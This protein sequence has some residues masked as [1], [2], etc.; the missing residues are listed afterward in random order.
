VTNS[1][2]LIIPLIWAILST[3]VTI[4]CAQ[5]E[6]SGESIDDRSAA[7]GTK[8]ESSPLKTFYLKDKDGKLVPY[9]DIPFEKFEEIYKLYK[10]LD[11]P[12]RPPRHVLE[13][14]LI[15]GT[16]NR[17]QA[18]LQ[19]NL[20]VS[21]KV[22]GWVR[23]PLGLGNVVLRELAVVG[24][25]NQQFLEYEEEG[26][27]YVCWINGSK[28]KEYKIQL[29]TISR[30]GIVGNKTSLDLDAPQTPFSQ[31]KLKIPS[32]RLESEVSK[33]AELRGIAKS[34]NGQTELNVLGVGPRFQLLWR[35]LGSDA[36]AAKPTL[37]VT[38]DILV[39]FI[40]QGQ[41]R[42]EA[43]LNVR[44]SRGPF[45]SFLVRLPPNM[46]LD[47]DDPRCFPAETVESPSAKP[48][49]TAEK[50]QLV[51]VTLTSATTGPEEVL[52]IAKTSKNTQAG[53]SQ[54][55][56]AGFQ[57]LG[58][59]FQSGFF[60]LAVKDD[61]SI[62]PEEGANVRREEDIPD[63]L[64]AKDVL[65]RFSYDAQ[66]CSLKAQAYRR[67]KLLNVEPR[68]LIHVT[69][70]RVH[71][72]AQLTCTLRGPRRSTINI[73]MTGWE[74]D[75][76]IERQLVDSKITLT[77]RVSP[78][79]IHLAPSVATSS[80]Q[81][82]LTIHASKSMELQDDTYGELR[83][84]I[85]RP[86]AT[87]FSPANVI[88]T[89]ESNVE[90]APN[91]T[92]TKGLVEEPSPPLSE[93][94]VEGPSTLVFRDRSEATR[95]ELVADMRLRKR[96]I[97]VVSSASVAFGDGHVSVQQIFK[98]QI[99]FEPL[100]SVLVDVP[101]QLLTLSDFEFSL[102]GNTLQSSETQNESTE[103]G[104]NDLARMRV[105]F[106]SSRR[107]A[108]NLL[109]TYSQPISAATVDAP[110][111]EQILLATQVPDSET[112]VGFDHLE[113]KT[114]RDLS[115][116][117]V[118]N[119]ESINSKQP[120]ETKN[121]HF[122]RQADGRIPNSF[123]ITIAINESAAARST[124]VQQAW[125]QTWL[126]KENR[127]DRAVFR[128]QTSDKSLSFILPSKTRLETLLLNGARHEASQHADA[129][130]IKVDVQ[131]DDEERQHV[132][133]F[134]YSHEDGRPKAGRCSLH[135]PQIVDANWTKRMYWQLVL[136]QDEHLLFGPSDLTPELSWSWEGFYWG[137]QANRTQRDLETST[138]ATYQAQLPASTNQYVFSSFGAVDQI[139]VTT[140]G[141]RSMM[142]G[143]SIVTL[144][145]GLLIIYFPSVRHPASLFALALGLVLFAAFYP[146]LS[147]QTAQ[148]ASLGIVFAIIVQLLRWTLERPREGRSV[149]RGTSRS[150]YDAE[151]T[152]TMAAPME[153]GS[154]A[155][156]S[157]AR[158]AIHVT[159]P[160]SHGTASHAK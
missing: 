145:V 141:R 138:A 51:K 127:Q 128:L 47:T 7:D 68:Y 92:E 90:L 156:V 36:A 123:E 58:T 84:P 153:I 118:G 85:P 143:V 101:R 115:A 104:T 157:S 25:P 6:D 75:E 112:S 22:D 122:F 61:W 27:G 42:C 15:D 3:Q 93:V 103:E 105:N 149:I 24:N 97:A 136:P 23:V 82:N 155:S 137:R 46:E 48:S 43:L 10:K 52:L 108:C 87:R 65:L 146:E 100:A 135:L 91:R 66:P 28:N 9:F 109:L 14:M 96:S 21:T 113:I 16:V 76:I 79:I 11:T 158:L 63:E 102:D 67:R 45:D 56:I 86:E 151:T 54:F 60:N 69:R 74:V 139:S 55:E 152:E 35:D 49:D 62:Q 117:I 140:A 129:G 83:L 19:I 34:T 57:V 26:D 50:S 132:L 144:V 133:E 110:V 89:S 71:L 64:R 72:E 150:T 40:T 81:F 134:W 32:R 125:I 59:P 160:I 31:M 126:G 116:A 73:D 80:N 5:P 41:V 88:V 124:V 131:S 94:P 121:R 98:N 159:E 12:S 142:L 13:S 130:E 39:N 148:V 99:E 37:H 30:L 106:P 1:R 38:G 20:S 4:A 17:K 95:A 111:T 78:L 147:L 120:H 53:D 77:D 2:L 33:G 114:T 18:N 119:W 29:R 154:K 44:S 70:D 8:V 107:G